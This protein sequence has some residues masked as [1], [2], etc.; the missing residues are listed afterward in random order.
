[1]IMATAN[2]FAIDFEAAG[3][4][5]YANADEFNAAMEKQKAID[6]NNFDHDK[7]KRLQ[8]VGKDLL[9]RAPGDTFYDHF[10]DNTI[11]LLAKD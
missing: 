1:M 11:L 5:V 2:P 10:G 3:L 8:Q 4:P 7:I 6:K 9:G